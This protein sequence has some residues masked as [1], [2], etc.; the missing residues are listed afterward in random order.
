MR[1]STIISSLLLGGS[2]AV[3]GFMLTPSFA[4]DVRMAQAGRTAQT[5]ERQWLSIQKVLDKLEAAGYR[6]FE[7][8]ER[9]HGYYEI[10]ALN[11]NGERTKLY[12][13]PQSG[14]IMDQA[15]RGKR[16]KADD[17]RRQRGSAFAD[18]N[19]RRCRDDLPQKTMP[20]APAAK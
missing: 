5:G 16:D 11:R 18:C 19:E 14:N 8:V 12:V 3:G 13:N 6:D 20:P 4:G 7:E 17:D 1:L 2:L 10:R 15:G 9:E